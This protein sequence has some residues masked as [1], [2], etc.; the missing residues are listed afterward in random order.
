MIV[1][2]GGWLV[3]PAR[4]ART[5][6]LEGL[7]RGAAV[8]RLGQLLRAPATYSHHGLIR[9]PGRGIQKSMPELQGRIQPD[10]P[11][12]TDDGV[13]MCSAQTQA[14]APAPKHAA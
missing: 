14:A 10:N 7:R 12:I 2:G 6:V 11:R 9:A 4:A 13:M 3:S 5:Q 8:C 1:K